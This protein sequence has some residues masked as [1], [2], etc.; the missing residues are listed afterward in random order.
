MQAVEQVLKRCAPGDSSR[1]LPQASLILR[2]PWGKE[3]LHS[4]I[5][6]VPD[7]LSPGQCFW[8]DNGPS[9]DVHILI[10]KFYPH[11]AL[12]V[13]ERESRLQTKLGRYSANMKIGRISWI[14]QVVPASSQG[15]LKVEVG[16]Q[17]AR[18]G[19]I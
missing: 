10:F 15:S 13:W 1:G 14:I 6:L 16:G 9:K 8:Q 5:S 3:S 19:A 18:V 7:S 12:Y 11:V 4:H 17:R 2:H